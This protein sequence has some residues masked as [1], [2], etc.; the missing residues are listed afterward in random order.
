MTSITRPTA[1]L[2]TAIPWGLGWGLEKSDQGTTFWH[3]GDNGDTTACVMAFD[4]QKTGVVMFANSSG[5]LSIIREVLDDALGGQH[6]AISWIN[7][8]RYDS[9]ARL[10]FK[11]ILKSDA[12]TV[13]SNYRKRRESGGNL[14]LTESQMNRL[15]YQL[16]GLKRVKDA[17]EVFRQN[18]VDFPE[19]FNTWDSLAEG[20]MINGDKESAIKYYK[21][22]LELNPENTNAVQ[23]L[24]E[25]SL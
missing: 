7:Y 13:L 15:G 10:M 4:K 11:A 20:L 12:E 18:T 5:G 1:P 2:S 23:K 25:L 22:S 3:W 14:P 24:K 8:E 16:L 19:A 6:P 9:P 17:I 21:K